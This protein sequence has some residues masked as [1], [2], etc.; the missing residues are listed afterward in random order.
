MRRL[1]PLLALALLVAP[2]RGAVPTASAITV[3]PVLTQSRLL[4]PSGVVRLSDLISGQYKSATP[5]QKLALL[6][7]VAG[8][9][10]VLS[11]LVNAPRQGV[12][13]NGLTYL[14]SRQP[15]NLPASTAGTPTSSAVQSNLVVCRSTPLTEATALAGALFMGTGVSSNQT[16]IYPGALFRDIDVVSGRF[17]PQMLPRKP[18]TLLI[19]VQNNGGTIADSVRNLNDRTQVMTAIN[20]LRGR[21]AAS[22]VNNA[23][24][25]DEFDATASAQLNLDV[26]T[27]ADVN[28]GPVL[29]LPI[30]PPNP[31]GVSGSASTSTQVTTTSSGNI[32]VGVIDQTFYTI[33]V[34]GE[35][36]ASTVDGAISSDVVVVTDVQYGRIAYVMVTSQ[37]SRVEAQTVV[38]ELVNASNPVASVGQN[39]TLS[40]A[41][42]T[43]LTTGSV[44]VRIMGGNAATAV[45]VHDLASLRNY[46]NQ[47]VPTVSGSNAVPIRYTL[48]YAADNTTA[49]MGALASYADRECA[50]AT[51]LRVKLKTITATHVVDFG[52]E[53]LYGTIS[54]ST[55]AGITATTDGGTFWDVAKSGAVQGAEN[56]AI[57]VQ[58]EIFFN[59]NPLTGPPPANLQFSI[60]IFDA[61]AADEWLLASDEAKK[62][63]YVSYTPTSVTVPLADIQ[64]ASN[65]V[66]QRSFTVT[67]GGSA[68]VSVAMEF[69][70]IP[71]Q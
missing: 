58:K 20:S 70:L 62:K 4:I 21:N 34:G 41:A 59:L 61:I 39:S 36:P 8:R 23:L 5:A 51:Q 26:E 55:P 45:T 22:A 46:V 17:T 47:I 48:R 68:T 11:Q 44:T 60:A 64:N 67:E 52:N 50:R 19:D 2:N 35:G 6:S 31:P 37:T 13:P 71:L 53:E 12:A 15:L 40:A 57:P 32:A 54:M 30:A 43:A 14:I 24:S 1:A 28:L 18:A 49:F 25:Y 3:N 16:V 65:H 9:Y 63:G 29:N 42:Q 69:E 10:K 33:S 38:S 56:S 66:L 27:S 7:Q